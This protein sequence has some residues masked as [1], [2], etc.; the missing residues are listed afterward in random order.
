VTLPISE[1]PRVAMPPCRVKNGNEHDTAAVSFPFFDFL[2]RQHSVSC[3]L[4]ANIKTMAEAADSSDSGIV[5][6]SDGESD[7][8]TGHNR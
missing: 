4:I 7:A 3:T 5:Q 8:A 1:A 2:I 6:I